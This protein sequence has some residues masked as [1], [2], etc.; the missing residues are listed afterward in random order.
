MA[1]PEYPLRYCGNMWLST[2]RV[3]PAVGMGV[4]GP[5]NFDAGHGPGSA[6]LMRLLRH[7]KG[8]KIKEWRM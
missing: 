4:A 3:T 7:S 8:Q 1:D 6:V 2:R 5:L